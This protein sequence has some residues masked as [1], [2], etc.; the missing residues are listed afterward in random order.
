M[1]HFITLFFLSIG[2][3]FGGVS[4]TDNTQIN[5]FKT[6]N[7]FKVAEINT[8]QPVKYGSKQFA[9]SKN[10]ELVSNDDP[11]NIGHDGWD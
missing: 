11:L 2:L 9:D 4:Q 10:Y 3:N 1:A 7:E 8:T 5:T 6:N